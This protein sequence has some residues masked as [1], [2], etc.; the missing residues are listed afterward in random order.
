MSTQ[1][2]AIAQRFVT[3]YGQ[4]LRY[5]A[6][7]DANRPTI[8]ILHGLISEASDW[9]PNIKVL[10]QQF[11]VIA[12]DLPGCGHSDKP[13]INYRIGT[14]VDYLH[15]FL[16]TL[17]CDCFSLIGHSLGALIAINFALTY[18]NQVDKLVNVSGGFGY[19][20]PDAD[21]QMLGFTPGSLKLLNPSTQA[22]V[23]QLLVLALYDQEIAQAEETVDYVFTVASNSGYVNERIVEL[24]KQGEDTLDGKLSTLNHPT[25]ILWGRQDQL[26]PVSLGERFQAELPNSQLIVF[27]E[28][29][30]NPYAEQFEKFNK[31]VLRF[32]GE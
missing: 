32:L 14:F 1:T 10:S 13:S 27:E 17:D 11:H 9:L 20:L 2:S 15:G 29:A 8:V 19:A 3:V 6:A 30:H 26:T 28:C 25:L 22:Q 7:G 4:N 21:P 24:F 5:L 31:K 18:P 16:Q 12:L 23:R